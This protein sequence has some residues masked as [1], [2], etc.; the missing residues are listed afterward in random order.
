M[1]QLDIAPTIGDPDEVNRQKQQ[2]TKDQSYLSGSDDSGMENSSDGDNRQQN[3]KR[4]QFI[5]TGKLK[6]S[7]VDGSDS[8][9]YSGDSSGNELSLEKDKM[10]DK[11]A[12]DG[13]SRRKGINYDSDQTKSTSSSSESNVTEAEF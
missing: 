9:D 4:R 11:R 10:I 12:T 5:K 3:Y 13:T 2:S 6:G 8:G 7:Y 1:R